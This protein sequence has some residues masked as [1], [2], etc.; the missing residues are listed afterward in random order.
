MERRQ[1]QLDDNLR[2]EISILLQNQVLALTCC[3]FYK[4]QKKG[5][6]FETKIMQSRIENIQTFS[7]VCHLEKNKNKKQNRAPECG[8]LN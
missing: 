8:N 6:I 2:R 3:F 7:R 4:Q 1:Q 5:E